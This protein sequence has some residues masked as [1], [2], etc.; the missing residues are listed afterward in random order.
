M[1]MSLYVSVSHALDNKTLITQRVQ[2]MIAGLQL[3]LSGEK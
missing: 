2:N 1:K 3:I